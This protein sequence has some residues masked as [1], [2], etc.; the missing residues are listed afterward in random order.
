MRG[1]CPGCEANLEIPEMVEVFLCPSCGWM[2]HPEHLKSELSNTVSS[3][4]YCDAFFEDLDSR[5][6][7]EHKHSPPDI[8]GR[9]RLGW[10]REQFFAARTE[11]GDDDYALLI[12]NTL[13]PYLDELEPE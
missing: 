12:R 3:T 2:G 8:E 13:R 4:E 5:I 1:F 6:S 10:Y 7:G 9:Q 11:M